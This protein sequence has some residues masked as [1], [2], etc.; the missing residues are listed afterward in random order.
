MVA[1]EAGQWG[2]GRSQASLTVTSGLGTWE[3][4]PTPRTKPGKALSRSTGDTIFQSTSPL[5]WGVL[6]GTVGPGED[7]REGSPASPGPC[8]LRAFLH[9]GFCV[10]L[11][12]VRGEPTLPGPGLGTSK[13]PQVTGEKTRVDRQKSPGLGF[14]TRSLLIL[15]FL[16]SLPTH[17]SWAQAEVV[18]SR[19]LG[20]PVVPIPERPSPPRCPRS[21]QPGIGGGGGS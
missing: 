11:N 3:E 19:R 7:R 16:A 4:R 8:I 2:P 9:S 5:W 20:D 12:P 13:L 1:G 6:A 10:D 17:V 21:P 15:W 18:G 14:C